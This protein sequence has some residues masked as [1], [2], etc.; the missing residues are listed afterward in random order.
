[1]VTNADQ[2]AA[3]MLLRDQAIIYFKDYLGPDCG[4][5]SIIILSFIFII[6]I[7]NNIY[8]FFVL[9]L[10]NSCLIYYFR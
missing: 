8:I 4:N 3:A 5:Q 10:K 6:L 7:T 9:I 2:V 1:M